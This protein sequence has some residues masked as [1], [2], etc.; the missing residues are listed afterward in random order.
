MATFDVGSITRAQDFSIIK[1]NEDIKNFVDQTN[2]VHAMNKQAEH[3]TKEVTDTKESEWYKKRQDAK[4]KG[5]NEYAGD[6]GQNRRGTQK[7]EEHPDRV[8]RKDHPGGFN[9]SV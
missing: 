2:V 8:I 1:H 5:G 6:G 3:L 4:D 7:R 9:V